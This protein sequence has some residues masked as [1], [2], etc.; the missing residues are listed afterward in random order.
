MTVNDKRNL[1]STKI[2]SL[3]TSRY[4][5][6]WFR[7]DLKQ[8]A[9]ERNDYI[10]KQNDLEIQKTGKSFVTPGN[11]MHKHVRSAR[12]SYINKFLTTAISDKP[13]AF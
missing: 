6:P 10:R 11:I 5:L 3:T 8:Y 9:K 7:K 2:I 13:N 4:N 12:L 1:V